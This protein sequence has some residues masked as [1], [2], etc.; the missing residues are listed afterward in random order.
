ML[1]MNTQWKVEFIP[2]GALVAGLIGM[3]S[4]AVAALCNLPDNFWDFSIFVLLILDAIAIVG[5]ITS[6]VLR[7][8]GARGR[9][10]AIC[11][12][13]AGIVG[14]AMCWIVLGSLAMRGMKM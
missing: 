13:F 10:R 5:G 7:W 12:I 9:K 14:L 1:D 6:I 3:L 8:D 4:C 11:A 2:M